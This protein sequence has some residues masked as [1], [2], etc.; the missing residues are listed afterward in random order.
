MKDHHSVH[1]IIIWNTRMLASPILS[2]T[3]QART[4]QKS[5]LH[6]ARQRAEKAIPRINICP[7]QPILKYVAINCKLKCKNTLCTIVSLFC[8]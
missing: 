3:K 8:Y 6:N 4:R 1:D 2:N 5:N 7:A